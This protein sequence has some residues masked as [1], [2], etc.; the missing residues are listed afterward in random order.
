MD[1]DNESKPAK[2]IRVEPGSDTSFFDQVSSRFGQFSDTYI[3]PLLERVWRRQNLKKSGRG[4]PSKYSD[5]MRLSIVN[6]WMRIETG[7]PVEAD[8]LKP[9][10]KKRFCAKYKIKDTRTLDN[11]IEE[12]LS[13][14]LL[15]EYLFDEN[16]GS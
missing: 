9:M 11:W 12:F 14:G 1:D 4:R 8:S 15:D 2:W 6:E 16:N 5:N 13:E 7:Q 10:T 3:N